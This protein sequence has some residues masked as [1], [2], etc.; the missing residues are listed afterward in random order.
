MNK[1]R[2]LMA[3]NKVQTQKGLSL[4]AFHQAYGSE[5]PCYAA[6]LGYGK[7]LNEKPTDRN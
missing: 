5:D 2:Y 7:D 3:R 6:L 4:R 1:R